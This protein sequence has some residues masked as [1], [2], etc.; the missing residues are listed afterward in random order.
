[1]LR[2]RVTV[3]DFCWGGVRH[4]FPSSSSDVEDTSSP[5]RILSRLPSSTPFPSHRPQG[6]LHTPRTSTGQPHTQSSL[7][8]KLGTAGTQQTLL[9]GMKNHPCSQKILT[10][11]SSAGAAPAPQLIV[12]RNREIGKACVTHI[13]WFA[14]CFLLSYS[15]L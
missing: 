7:V 4:C 8:S 15:A 9:T 11:Q 14:S 12:L 6:N 1:M 2:R 10:E 5:M 3:G 13:L